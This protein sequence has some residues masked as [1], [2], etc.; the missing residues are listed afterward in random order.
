MN[1]KNIAIGFLLATLMF[2]T[3]G[4]TEGGYGLPDYECPSGQI[5]R[6]FKQGKPLCA[7]LDVRVQGYRSSSPQGSGSLLTIN[8]DKEQ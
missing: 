3:I 5:M 6:G 1:M 7:I 8:I 4:W 2:A